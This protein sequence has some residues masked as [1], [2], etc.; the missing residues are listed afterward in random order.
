MVRAAK[1]PY[2]EKDTRAHYASLDALRDF[3][4]GFDKYYKSIGKTYIA[5]QDAALEEADIDRFVDIIIESKPLRL[6]LC[7]N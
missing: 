3:S 5:D 2:V 7:M 4:R 1:I 6:Y